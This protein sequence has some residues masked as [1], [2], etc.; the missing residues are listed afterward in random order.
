MTGFNDFGTFALAL[1]CVVL[2]CTCLGLIC[3]LAWL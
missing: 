1:L 3:A 2:L